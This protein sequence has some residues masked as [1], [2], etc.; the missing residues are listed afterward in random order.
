MSMSAISTQGFH[1]PGPDIANLNPS[2]S[3]IRAGFW[4]R[5][6]QYNADRYQAVSLEDRAVAA[7][8]LQRAHEAVDR[9]CGVSEG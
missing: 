2:V 6:L 4:L 7:L 9:L 1:Q 3:R 5:V 8:K